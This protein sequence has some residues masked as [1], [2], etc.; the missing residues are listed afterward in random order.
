MQ[1]QDPQQTK[2]M[3]LAVILSIGVMVLWQVLYAGPQM[4][5][6]RERQ[7]Q[8]AQEQQQTQTAPGAGQTAAPSAGV[9]PG[10]GTPGASGVT[11]PS[12]ATPRV[13]VD[14]SSALSADTRVPL[15]T[16]AIRGSINLKGGRIDD[17]VLKQYGVAPDASSDRV[18]LFSPQTAPKPYFAINFWVAAPGT[19]VKTPNADT[20]W[21]AEGS[22]TLTP[23]APLKLTWENGE[24]LTFTRTISVDSDYLFTIE[25]TVANTSANA[26]V[27]FPYARIFR[28]GIP[29]DLE[30]FFIQHEG[31]IGVL[32][33]NGFTE[34]DYS[35]LL[36]PGSGTKI[37]NAQGGWL[38]FTDKYWGAALIPDQSK[39]FN[40]ALYAP[41]KT[42][43]PGGRPHFHAE[44]TTEG[45][46]VAPG[47]TGSTKLNLY[48]GAKKVDLVNGYEAA[49]GVRQFELMIDWGWFYFITKPLYFLLDWLFKL[50]GNFGVAILAV[51][52]IVKALFFYFANKSYESMAKMKKLQPEMEKIR[53]RYENDKME[54]QKHLMELYKSEKINPLAGCLPVLVQIPVFFALYKVLFI[55]IDMRHA[56]FF[57]WIQ[58]LSAPDPTSLFN[59]FGL[60][61]YTMPDWFPAV[62][63]WPLIMGITMWLQMQLNPQQPDPMQQAIFNW[64]PVVFTFLLA[65][66]PAGLVIYWAWN[67][68]LSLGQQYFIMKR[69]GV[70]V[71]LLDNIKRTGAAAKRTAG[72]ISSKVRKK[73]GG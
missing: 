63:I 32:G 73:E 48:A 40:A 3:I 57:G 56:P 65:S 55:S 71:H 10:T 4:E 1:T 27:L 66:F 9:Q 62:G 30:N 16:P 64:M 35:E 8:L 61:P 45:V 59:L 69:Q 5:Q 17:I 54:Q 18:V 68:I 36:E 50:F 33:E 15:D 26:V 72:G 2:N 7:R 41:V 31:L 21:S 38:G 39:P 42:P 12:V 67:N 28:Y 58:D 70:D 6:Q 19:N 51:T 25:D 11:T 43:G 47:G 20:V 13:L 44:Y 14:R 49:L 37:S 24:G 52:V 23:A 22:P 46:T 29:T 60:L 34:L 53:K